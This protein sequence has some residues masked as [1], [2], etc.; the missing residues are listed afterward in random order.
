MT[1]IIFVP[2]LGMRGPGWPP[3]PGGPPV[4]SP[5]K[6]WNGTEWVSTG[7]SVIAPP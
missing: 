3:T 2:P 1:G 7:V 4:D 5:L 6:V